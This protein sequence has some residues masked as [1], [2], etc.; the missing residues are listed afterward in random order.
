MRELDVDLGGLVHYVDH[1]G[2]GSPLVLLHGLG[3]SRLN[4]MA[5]APLLARSHRVFALEYIGHG[6]TPLAG[7]KANLA[8]H[9]RVAA[10]L[11]YLR[12]SP[13]TTMPD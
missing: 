10:V 5:V 11:T 3:G 12:D 1:G 9:R 4:W 2:Q 7:R 8:G 6:L 13:R